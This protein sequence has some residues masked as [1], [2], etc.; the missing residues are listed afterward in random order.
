M[1]RKVGVCQV[2]A[3]MLV[4]AA[5]MSAWGRSKAPRAAEKAKDDREIQARAHYAA[6]R[7]QEAVD[8]FA[9]LYA[10][11]ADPVY[12]RNIGRCYQKLERPEDAIRS[13]EAYLE[14]TPNI[15]PKER[16]EVEGYIRQ[17]NALKASRGS[18][19]VPP[20]P[21]EPVKVPVKV[22]PREPAASP[23]PAVV[24]TTSESPKPRKAPTS[25]TV[26]REGGH[27]SGSSHASQLGM[28]FRVDADV[29]G[30]GFVLAPG[31]TFGA[32]RWIELEANALLGE[33]GKGVW[34]GLRVLLG[35]GMLK[36]AV[37]AG[38][39]LFFKEGTR[40]GIQ[41]AA[42]VILDAGRHLGLSLDLGVVH[43]FSV[44]A[45]YDATS[46]VV[47]IGVQARL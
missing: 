6:G 37:R 20:E 1:R 45:T 10:E 32:G 9:R 5:S 27:R 21:D 47:S 46:F 4:C 36:P 42:G 29:Q 16:K 2:L 24:D 38:A 14:K 15:A 31:L 43:L 12:L 19:Q 22:P 7:F 41:G 28:V 26:E 40:A 8:L 44:P 3:I 35:S 13:F 39:P 25:L 17:M 33:N 34:A 18:A 23:E 30:G 11:G